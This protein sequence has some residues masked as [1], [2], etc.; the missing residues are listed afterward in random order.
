MKYPY[1]PDKRMFAAVMCACR[2][3]RESG[4]FNKAVAYAADTFNVSKKELAMHIRKRQA[5]SQ[6]KKKTAKGKKYKWFI[7]E[8]WVTSDADEEGSS[9]GFSVIRASS[10]DNAESH[11]C[12]SDFE[13][14]KR[15]DYGGSYAHVFFH[16]IRGNPDGY[17]T[18]AE[19]LVALKKLQTECHS[20]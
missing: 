19:A 1:I 14:T 11:F 18:K 2:M 12:T 7:S 5:A 16:Y 17:P 9:L 6:R 4:W 10:R 3:I 20:S 13:N 8:K 15:L